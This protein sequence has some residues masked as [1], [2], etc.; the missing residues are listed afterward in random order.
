MEGAMMDFCERLW[1]FGFRKNLGHK[2]T[3]KQ[4]WRVSKNSTF[5]LLI[6]TNDVRVVSCQ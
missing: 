4:C 5:K 1:I 2:G 3:A 6:S